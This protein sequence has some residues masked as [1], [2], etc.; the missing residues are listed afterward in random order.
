MF[1][2]VTSKRMKDNI[3]IRVA[4]NGA[5]VREE[6]KDKILQPFYTTKET[7]KGT[8]LGLS[9]SYG[10]I[11]ELK[12]DLEIHSKVLKGTAVTITLPVGQE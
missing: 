5:G 7:G 8:G 11:R 1:I 10:L 2:E 4:D 9:I 3:L 12:G 6:H